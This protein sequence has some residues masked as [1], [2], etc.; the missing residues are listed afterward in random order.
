MLSFNMGVR[1]IFIRGKMGGGVAAILSRYIHLAL[2]HAGSEESGG[3]KLL[4]L[5]CT[6]NI[7]FESV[8]VIY[9]VEK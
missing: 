2:A 6:E 3:K 1:R 4:F 8:F 7:I 9:P 5:F